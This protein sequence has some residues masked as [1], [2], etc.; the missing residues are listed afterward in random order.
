MKIQRYDNDTPIPPGETIKEQIDFNNLT[1]D[2]F[3]EAMGFTKDEAEDLLA[4]KTHITKTI[5]KKLEKVLI[6]PSH[7]WLSLE[8]FDIKGKRLRRKIT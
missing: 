3:A 5:A 4:G 8:S 1:I 6:I 2:S 7:F